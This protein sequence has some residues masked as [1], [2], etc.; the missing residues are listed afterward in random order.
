MCGL[1]NY[2]NRMRLFVISS[3]VV[4]YRFVCMMNFILTNIVSV[5]SMG[6]I[7]FTVKAA[8]NQI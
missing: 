1:L 4:S 6:M 3:S 2:S 8:S 7:Y 5:L